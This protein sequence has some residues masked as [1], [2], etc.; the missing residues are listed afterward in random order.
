MPSKKPR[1][2]PA[3]KAEPKVELCLNQL[4]LSAKEQKDFEMAL[5]SLYKI[6]AANGV[7][8]AIAP[9]M[10]VFNGFKIN[11]RSIHPELKSFYKDLCL[12]AVKTMGKKK[13]LAAN[14]VK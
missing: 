3:N 5:I 2:S 6:A 1:V 4:R 13:F 14:K 11:G 7:G 10:C 9:T 12:Q 8:V